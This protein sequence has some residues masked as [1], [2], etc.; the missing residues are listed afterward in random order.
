MGKIVKKQ[1]IVY[2]IAIAIIVII[3]ILFA[4]GMNGM[5][6]HGN[7]SFMNHWNWTQI[8]VSMAI[9]FVIGLLVSKRKW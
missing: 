3:I 8:L 6:N 7:S 4:G 5:M 2:V 9:G 1:T